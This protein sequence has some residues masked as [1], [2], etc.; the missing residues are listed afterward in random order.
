[1]PMPL[2]SGAT[3]GE[4]TIVRLLGSGR[5]GEAYLVTHPKAPRRYALKILSDDMSAD[6]EFRQRFLREAKLAA[7]LDHPH[8][9]PVHH[10]GVHK[11]QLWILMDHVAGPHIDPPL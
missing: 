3:F 6:A 2:T 1:M 11:G 5:T 8:I 4:F 9:V 10:R 7:A